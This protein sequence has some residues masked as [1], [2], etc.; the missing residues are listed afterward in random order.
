[1]AEEIETVS[2]RTETSKKHWKFL[3]EIFIAHQFRS[4]GCYPE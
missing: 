3:H 1:M 2:T 4:I